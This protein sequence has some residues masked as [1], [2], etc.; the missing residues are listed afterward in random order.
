MHFCHLTEKRM[1][2]IFNSGGSY[3]IVKMKATF[4]CS[5]VHNAFYFWLLEATCFHMRE[6]WSK[7]NDIKDTIFSA[8]YNDRGASH[9]DFDNVCNSAKGDKESEDREAQ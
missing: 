7:S 1:N 9:T 5:N 6:I 4:I 8:S 2:Y 3:T